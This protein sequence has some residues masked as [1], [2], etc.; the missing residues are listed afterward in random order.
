MGDN[1]E[2]YN[3]FRYINAIHTPQMKEDVLEAIIS[4]KIEII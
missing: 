3:L 1:P 2:T 4:E